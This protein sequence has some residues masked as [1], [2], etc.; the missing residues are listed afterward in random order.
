MTAAHFYDLT[1]CHYLD[2]F[3]PATKF[4]LHLSGY[5]QCIPDSTPWGMWLP[6][7]HH[8]PS[9]VFVCHLIFC[10]NDTSSRSLPSQH[11]SW[12]L[13]SRCLY[14]LLSYNVFTCLPDYCVSLLGCKLDDSTG[15]VLFTTVFSVRPIVSAYDRRFI[16]KDE[17]CLSKQ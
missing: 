9:N 2:Y 14:H 13:Y 5:T 8:F 3:S 10:S 15:S 16:N 12:Y 6:W 11:P 7:H 1:S 17:M 4:S